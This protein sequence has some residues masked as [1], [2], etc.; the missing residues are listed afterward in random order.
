MRI[1]VTGGTG[2][3][4]SSLA[5]RLIAL[6]H[7]V[8]VSAEDFENPTPDGADPYS[9]TQDICFHQAANNDT[10]DGDSE[11]MFKSNLHEPMELFKRMLAKGCKKFI[12]ASSTAV[13][14][15]SECPYGELTKTD[16]LNPYARSKLAFDE[17]AM[18]FA[19][20]NKVSVIGLRYCNVYGPK[21]QHKGRRASMIYQFY[22]RMSKG[23]RPRLFKFGEQKR[24]MCYV[25]D[26]VEANVKCMNYDGSGIFNVGSGKPTS[27]NEMVQIINLNLGSNLSPEYLDCPFEKQYQSHTECDISAANNILGWRP[28]YT[29]ERGIQEYVEW[30]KPRIFLQPIPNA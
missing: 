17:F 13:Y 4:G 20:E 22:E 24:D 23:L 7:K 9:E 27:F 16:P 3:V 15:N 12:Y 10:L 19:K 11:G 1:L 6:G 21:E 29:I 8:A 5:E 14:G 2:F 26:I 25:K 30:L 28:D 18:N